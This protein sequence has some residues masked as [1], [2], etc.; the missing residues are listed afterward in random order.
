MDITAAKLAEEEMHRAQADLTR[1]TR[2]ATMAELTASI[3]HE[4]NK[5]ISG[6]LTNSEA[7]LRLINRT[8]PDIDE[9]REAVAR[10]V[11]GARRGGE[12]VG[13]LRAMFCDM[14]PEPQPFRLSDLVWSKLP[15]VRSHIY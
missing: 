10:G 14:A 13:P 15:L 2:I 12:V 11:V 9:A 5:P 1:V 6:V 3:A 7:C 4:I 8:E